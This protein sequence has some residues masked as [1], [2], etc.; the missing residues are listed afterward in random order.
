[1]ILI[2]T[3]NFL[4]ADCY[5]DIDK[6]SNELQFYFYKFNHSKWFD[7]K[8]K[9]CIIGHK[10][11]LSHDKNKIYPHNSH[12]SKR[13]RPPKP[14]PEHVSTGHNPSLS[15]LRR[16]CVRT[17][18]LLHELSVPNTFLWFE[19]VCWVPM[20]LITKLNTV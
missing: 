12:T 19:M 15:I 1:M 13:N 7:N 8:K 4:D 9:E 16:Y 14:Q 20:P 11:L 17:P 5:I 18:R 10:M 3:D 6:T 2:D